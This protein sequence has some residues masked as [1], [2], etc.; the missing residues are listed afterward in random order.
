MRT[1]TNF[2]ILALVGFAALIASACSVRCL[3]G[4]GADSGL[5][6]GEFSLVGCTTTDYSVSATI[7][8]V[9][10]F[11]L[12]V[13]SGS[14]DLAV[15]S[16]ACSNC[17]GLS[18]T[19]DQT[20]GSSQHQSL[21]D[22]YGSGQ[23]TGSVYSDRILV[24]GLPAI[25]ATFAAITSQ[26]SFF[27]NSDC[28]LGTSGSNKDQGIMGMAF[29]SIAQVTG[30]GYMDQLLAQNPV[31]NVFATQLC[32]TGGNLWIG[33]YDSSFMAAQPQ[34]AALGTEQYY[35]VTMLDL[36]VG[37]ASLGLA[38]S[39]YHTPIVDTGTSITQ[40][41]SAV[42]AALVA[43]LEANAN[44]AGAFGAGFFSAGDCVTSAMTPS[45]L[46]AQ[47]PFLAISFAS[48]TSG[49][50]FS[51]SLPPTKSY[52][53]MHLNSSG[54]TQYYCP[55]VSPTATNPPIVGGSFLRSFV[56]VFDR[57]YARLGFATQAGCAY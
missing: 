19:Y 50:A 42:Y 45:Q 53:D 36:S 3:S 47:L 14:T 29:S 22:V 46:D 4:C 51:V 34:Y 10:G 1:Q 56:T 2:F 25:N 41:P 54:T 52:L 48:T 27:T 55:G 35:S 37:G 31:P 26:S 40:L 20:H 30:G 21:T 18:P 5:Y 24:G 9:P 15:A 43:A 49:Q 57:A 23:W 17:P 6:P 13:D 16:S 8:G 28:N 38:A 7:G 33:G 12:I 32:E 39:A 44:F 11:S